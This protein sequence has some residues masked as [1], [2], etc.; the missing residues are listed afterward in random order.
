[1]ELCVSAECSPAGPRPL[2]ASL[3]GICHIQQFVWG[4]SPVVL[5]HYRS[6]VEKKIVFLF[7]VFRPFLLFL[8]NAFS[9]LYVDSSATA[10]T[11]YFESCYCYF[12]YFDWNSEDNAPIVFV[13]LY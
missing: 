8:S 11:I 2:N 1:M 3:G 7:K 9:F 13:F 12:A 5:H 10:S 4:H 6:R